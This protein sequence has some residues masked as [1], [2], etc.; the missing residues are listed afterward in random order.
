MAEAILNKIGKGKIDAY[1]AGS[2]PVGVVNPVALRLLNDMGYKT[3]NFTSKSMDDFL[4]FDINYVI[5]VC[6]NAND[7]CPIFP[8]NVKKIHWGLD[9]P[10]AYDGDD[11]GKYSEFK[12]IYKILEKNLKDFVD[13]L[14]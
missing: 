6:D 12:R 4:G 13:F 3:D 9:D 11:E 14:K 8:E 5:T 10:A 7:E 1:S 2:R